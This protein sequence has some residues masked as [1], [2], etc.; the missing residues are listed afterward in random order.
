MDNQLGLHATVEY[1]TDTH[2]L[3]PHVSLIVIGEPLVL[4]TRRPDLSFKLP[5]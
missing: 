3:F 1:S 5:G 2:H 4:E